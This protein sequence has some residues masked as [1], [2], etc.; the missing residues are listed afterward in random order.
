[1]GLH[2]INFLWFK[3]NARNGKQIVKQ[4]LFCDEY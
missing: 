2:K 1:M 4:T 3:K